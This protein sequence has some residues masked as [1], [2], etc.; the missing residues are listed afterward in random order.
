MNGER[1]CDPCYTWT[2]RDWLA[3]VALWI[4]AAVIVAAGVVLAACM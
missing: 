4:V 3:E 1:Y 2:L